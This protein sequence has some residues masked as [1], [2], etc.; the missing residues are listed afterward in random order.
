[1]QHSRMSFCIHHQAYENVWRILPQYHNELGASTH[2]KV[3]M[4]LLGYLDHIPTKYIQPL[5]PQKKSSGTQWTTSIVFMSNMAILHT[6]CEK[7][8][9][10]EPAT[11]CNIHIQGCT[12]YAQKYADP[13]VMM[14]LSI[15]STI[16]EEGTPSTHA[17]GLNLVDTYSLYSFLLSSFQVYSLD[18]INWYDRS[19]WLSPSENEKD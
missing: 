13:M 16:K 6:S 18:S 1:M 12:T 8:K 2:M 10:L 9:T 5:C 11:T 19:D 4:Y 17:N 15:Q 3:F 7:I 14:I